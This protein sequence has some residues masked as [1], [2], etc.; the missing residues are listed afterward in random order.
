[1]WYML[2]LYIFFGLQLSDA[3]L[4]VVVIIRL[5]DSCM[6]DSDSVARLCQLSF[7]IGSY[8]DSY[9]PY[10]CSHSPG[11]YYSIMFYAILRQPNLKRL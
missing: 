4:S 3:V 6:R 7:S 8:Y 11:L 2:T 10:T 5:V 9:S 1:M